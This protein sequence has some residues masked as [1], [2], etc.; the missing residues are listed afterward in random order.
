MCRGINRVKVT[1][2]KYRGGL[3]LFLGGYRGFEVFNPSKARA[4]PRII[5]W[6]KAQ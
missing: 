4:L 5:P 3:I 6:Y 1:Y 2:A